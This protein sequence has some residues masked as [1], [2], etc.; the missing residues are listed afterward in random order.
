MAHRIVSLL[1][2]SSE[3]VCALGLQDLL[4]GRSHECDFPPP[5]QNL[6][7]CSRPKINFQLSSAA[8]DHQVRAMIHEGLSLFL[9]DEDLLR[10][11]QPTLILTQ[12]HCKVCAVS[13]EDV[14][15]AVCDWLDHTVPIVSLEPN[16]LDNIWADIQTVA[17]ALDVSECGK[18]VVE[19]LQGRMH[20]IQEA[21][22][23]LAKPRVATIEW[24]DPIMSGGNWLPT[25]VEMAGGINMFGHAAKNSPAVAFS[26]IAEADPDVIVI[27]PC[28]FGIQRT[29]DELDPLLKQ[30][31]WSD[32]KAVQK[33]RVYVADGHHYFNRP[34]PRIVESLEILA[35]IFHSERFDFGHR[36]KGWELL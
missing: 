15:R 35:E 3:I 10:E 32:L 8:I 19:S 30:P 12:V 28:G 34:G 29:R 24:I 22:Q 18:E 33:Q 26:K 11:L 4:V 25:L 17:N 6:P 14:Q 9:V 20:S 16:S 23:V 21:A 36:N 5:L 27:L 1:P 13:L 7:I 2:S 31:G